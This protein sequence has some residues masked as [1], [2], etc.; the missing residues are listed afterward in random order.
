MELIDIELIA[1]GTIRISRGKAVGKGPEM[2]DIDDPVSA[3]DARAI[4]PRVQ[5]RLAG[6][7]GSG[8]VKRA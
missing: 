5:H 3:S 7:F 1:G 8:S 2:W 6:R 4:T